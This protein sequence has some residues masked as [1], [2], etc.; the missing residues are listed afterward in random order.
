MTLRCIR[1]HRKLTRDPIEGMGPT[2][3]R[4]MLGSKPKRIKREDKR[5][6]DER[7]RELFH[8]I[9]SVSV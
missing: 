1:C 2:C 3:A 9:F 4:A 7:Q 6:N 8:P 5:S